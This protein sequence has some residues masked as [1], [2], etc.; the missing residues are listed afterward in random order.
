MDKKKITCHSSPILEKELK[1]I[2]IEWKKLRELIKNVKT[3]KIQKKFYKSWGEVAIIDQSKNFIAGYTDNIKC[4]TKE[5]IVFGDHT[6]SIKFINFPFVQ[7][8]D[9]IKILQTKDNLVSLKYIYY[10]MCNFIKYDGKYRRHW[11]DIS[12]IPIPIPS[13]KEQERIVKILDK[14]TELTAVL[15]AELTASIKQYEY[16]SNLLIS[17]LN[18]EINWK[19]LKEIGIILPGLKSKNKQDFELNNANSFF[20]KY[21]DVFNDNLFLKNINGRVFV[22]EQEKQNSIKFKDLLITASSESLVDA[23]AVTEAP[24]FFNERNIYLNSFCRIFRPN[25]DLF[26]YKFLK[27]IFKSKKFKNE[28]IKTY[29]GTTRFNLSVKKLENILIPIPTIQEQQILIKI[30]DKFETLTSNL[31]KGL[32]KEIELI[33]KQYEYYR[34]KLLSFEGSK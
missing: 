5:S 3:S 7:G 27:F 32:P 24:S 25:N 11:S 2:K 15:T 13:L 16:Y 30:L 17:N 19:T 23:G 28:L 1:K 34:N 4:I 22:D 29:Q 6:C 18:L 26:E 9:G 21:T 31:E 20:V 33:N 8:A 10:S 12:N 14:F